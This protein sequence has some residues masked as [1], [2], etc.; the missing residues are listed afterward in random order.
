MQKTIVFI[1]AVFMFVFSFTGCGYTEVKTPDTTNNNPIGTTENTNKSTGKTVTVHI[2]SYIQ[3]GGMFS[4]KTDDGT[5]TETPA[6]TFEEANVGEKM[7]DVFFN[8]GI[9]DVEPKLEGD[10]FEGWMIFKDVV[11]T[12]SE[13]LMNFSFELVSGD[14]FYTTEQLK[15]LAVPEYDVTYIAKWASLDAE[16]YFKE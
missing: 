11:T 14:T 8:S 1:V 13:G 7:A 12:D 6:W 2:D 10:T 16:D 3:I 9:V 15:E 5:V 4:V